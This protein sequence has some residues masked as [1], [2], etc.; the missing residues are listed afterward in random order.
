MG[1]MA[2]PVGE[3][4][5]NFVVQCS[6]GVFIAFFLAT[7][8]ANKRTCAKT[9]KFYDVWAY[10]LMVHSRFQNYRIRQRQWSITPPMRRTPIVGTPL[11]SIPAGMFGKYA[12]RT[13]HHLGRNKSI[14]E[15]KAISFVFADD[16]FFSECYSV[17]LGQWPDEGMLPELS[18][19]LPK[20]PV[21]AASVLSL[22]MVQSLPFPIGGMRVSPSSPYKRTGA[23]VR[24][25]RRFS[26]LLQQAAWRTS[27]TWAGYVRR[28]AR[29]GQS[30]G[31][32]N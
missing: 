25:V 3:W 31:N 30:E 23:S 28:L 8:P 15:V 10:V 2:K 7:P 26:I 29:M 13:T 12:A 27:Y 14:A 24:L 4:N 9:I 1:S 17:D 16:G 18:G 19:I 5:F 22:P 6:G 21:L 11:A 20:T 32:P